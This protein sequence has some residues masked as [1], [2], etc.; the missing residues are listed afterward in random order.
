MPTP[1]CSHDQSSVAVIL[2]I[3]AFHPGSSAALL[4]D[5]VPVAAIAEERLNRIKYYAGFPKLA[6]S[7]CLEIAGLELDN[8]EYVAVGRDSS[9]NLHKKLEF[10]LRNP[11]RLLNL[12][13]IRGK[14]RTFDDMRSMIGAEFEYDPQ[15]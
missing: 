3:N 15:K 6:I 12:A 5:G 13:R 8:I 7:R 9:A 2:G 11:S 14:S 4:V 10:A 1:A